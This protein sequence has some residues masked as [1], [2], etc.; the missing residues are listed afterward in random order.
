MTSTMNPIILNRHLEK[1][2]IRPVYYLYGEETYLIEEAVRKIE[3]RTISPDFKDFNCETYYGGSHTAEEIINAART[4]PVMSQKRLIIVKEADCLSGGNLEGLASYLSNPSSSSCLVFIGEKV[5]RRKRFFVNLQKY[6]VAAQ[7][8]HPKER[9]IPYWIRSLAERSHKDIT[10]DAVTFL[11]EVVG[12]NL[13]EMYNEIEK[14]SIFIGDKS[15]IGLEDVEAV[16]TELKAENIFDLID[17][18]GNK[19]AEKALNI[20]QKML[21]SG[22]EH[23]KIL[24]MIMYRFRL[25]VRA[26]EMLEKGLPPPEVGKK[27]GVRGFFLKGFLQQVNRFSLHEL[28]SA[29]GQFLNADLAL[30]SSRVPKKLVLERLIL[31]LCT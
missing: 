13:Q 3:S 30:K 6:G 21:A 2:E 8:N 11:V 4:V 23:L 24:G 17:S 22:E 1:D 29:F 14:V 9:E 27:L 10:R 12:G 5:D 7:L 26:K 18:M 16:V 31:D 19:D 25:I 28:K 20:L 15:V